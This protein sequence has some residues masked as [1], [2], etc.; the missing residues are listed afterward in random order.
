LGERN[1]PSPFFL[2]FGM[3]HKVLALMNI[4]VRCSVNTNGAVLAADVR[5]YLEVNLLNLLFKKNESFILIV[6]LF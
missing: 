5:S 1:L 2:E 4:T 3:V 6:L